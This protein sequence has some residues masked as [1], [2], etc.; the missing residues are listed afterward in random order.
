MT[1]TTDSLAAQHSSTVHANGID[2]HCIEAG[3][4]DPLILLHGGLVSTSDLWASTPI[5]YGSHLERLGRRF[6][7][8]APDARASGRT[9]H[10]GGPVSASLLADD[11]AALIEA[12]G[13]ERPAV[14]G[15]S[16]GGLTALLLGIRHPNSVGAIVCDAGNDILNPD[17]PALSMIPSILGG[18]TEI[19]PDVIAQ[20]LSHDPQL[21]AVI[22]MMQADQD[23]AQGAGAWR[24]YLTR[25]FE[26]WS[27]WPGYG[28][29]DL[30]EIIVPTLVLVGDRDDFCS[31]E[32]AVVAYR[33]LPQGELA[34]APD[35]GHVITAEKV[36]TLIA[37]LDR[38]RS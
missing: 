17:A 3:A 4:G 14:A 23:A 13:L 9:G 8:V 26:R 33:S 25:T 1:P 12:L 7:V 32:E 28:Y 2:I 37:F 16:E 18:S 10:T 27:R 22:A 34:V 36:E 35:T 5:S 30:A 31:A 21:A 19:D 15:F 29:A 11:V 24:T 6:R 20:A 38:V